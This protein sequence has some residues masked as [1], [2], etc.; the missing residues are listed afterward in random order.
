[1][2]NIKE[3]HQLFVE[4]YI[5]CSDVKT[6]AE[7]SNLSI[8]TAYK[9]LKRKEIKDLIASS[10]RNSDIKNYCIN[11]LV[12]IIDADIK[13]Y[14]NYDNCPVQL[15]SLDSKLT[16]LVRKVK[17]TDKGTEIELYD[18]LRAIELLLKIDQAK[19]KV[20]DLKVK[21]EIIIQDGE[22]ITSNQTVTKTSK[23]IIEEDED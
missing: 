17:N 15:K 6:A 16:K 19:S 7:R 10:K 12:N 1:M 23:E 18:K 20:S 3:N 9:L 13:D 11:K 8:P 2:E 5:E 22:I 21:E 14:I 4:N